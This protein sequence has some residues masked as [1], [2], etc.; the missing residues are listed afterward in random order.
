MRTPG[1]RSWRAA[2]AVGLLTATVPAPAASAEI[3]VG[4]ASVIG[5]WGAP[6]EEGGPT[7]PACVESD[8]RAVCKPVA[9]ALGVLPDGRLLYFDG[10]S[11][12]E[13][14]ARL[15]DL[16][17]GGPV[18]STPGG[19]DP[20]LLGADVASLGEGRLLV[21][22]GAGRRTRLYDPATD[23][24][25]PAGPM[26]LGRRYPVAVTLPDGRVMVAGGAPQEAGGAPDQA[27]GAGAR[28]VGPTEIFDPATGA[29]A[30]AGSGPGSEAA[31]PLSP[32]LHLMP[33]GKVLYTAVGESAFPAAA[34]A[35]ADEALYPLLRFFDPDRGR[36]DVVGAD[37]LGVR[38]GA[39]TVLLALDPPY[40]HATVL[41]FGGAL[42]PPPSSAV[43]TSLVTETD[44][45]RSGHLKERK[46]RWEMRGGRW[47]PSGVVLPDGAVLAVGGAGTSETAAPEA[48][49]PA[50]T[51]EL[52]DPT[53][54]QW[55]PMAAANRDHT[56]GQ[57]A[58][59]LPDGRVLLGGHAPPAAPGP[60]PAAPAPGAPE[61]ALG[62]GLP[63][64]ARDA[65]FE[66]FSPYYLFRGPRPVIT[67]VN[68]S[69]QYLQR[70]NIFTTDA[71]DI[72]TVALVRNPSA[73]HLVDGDQRTVDVP[74]VSRTTKSVTVAIPSNT[75]LP[76]GPYM[77]FVNRGT[78][79]GEI[80]SVS[81]QVFV[82]GPVPASLAPRLARRT[83]T[84]TAAESR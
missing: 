38:D 59:L 35:T 30:D 66:I 10:S 78:A 42:G 29:W 14:E 39:G 53:T 54:E 80:P 23:R 56:Y 55:S 6:F 71:A 15:L 4:P 79:S 27:A 77:L 19:T 22:G 45:D 68:P 73:T 76:P 20:G 69:V 50:R 31:L 8:G 1:R 24:F 63:Q 26:R 40:D 64:R 18:W 25:T 70:F 75:V 37:T 7:A 47:N 49:L 58:V 2:L 46:T 3:T 32:H 84:E 74:I 60:E 83:T 65:S 44:V 33:N 36:W 17:S 52:F 9:Q 61:P 34:D 62:E 11:G 43:G 82:G 13:G 72:T 21:A 81:R 5:R 67:Y 41:T 48:G 28:H 57:S 51:A 12:G 16:R